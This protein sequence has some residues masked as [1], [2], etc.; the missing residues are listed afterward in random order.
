MTEPWAK[1]TMIVS[2]IRST[3]MNCM[4]FTACANHMF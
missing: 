2:F 4:M 3:D 1:K